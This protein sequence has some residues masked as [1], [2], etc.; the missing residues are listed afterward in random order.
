MFNAPFKKISS[1]PLMSSNRTIHE[2][3]LTHSNYQKLQPHTPLDPHSRLFSS[4]PHDAPV[5]Q[6]AVTED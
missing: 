1:G 2:L 5:P 4:P 6:E 3:L